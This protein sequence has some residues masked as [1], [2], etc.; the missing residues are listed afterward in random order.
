MVFEAGRATPNL[1]SRDLSAT[2]AFY[3]QL[4][5][6]V[7]FVDDTWLILER[8]ALQIEFFPWPELDPRTTIASCCLRVGD[9]DALYAAF[10][11]AG[12]ASSAQSIPRLVAP[13]NQHWGLREGA[14]VDL[15][16][17]LLRLLGPIV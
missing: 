15:D 16:G 9:V 1:P 10:A 14:L 17:N 4:G 5:F 8:G 13:E 11:T 12:L 3:G 6:H 2:A 7:A